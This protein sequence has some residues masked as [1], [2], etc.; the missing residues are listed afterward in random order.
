MP[1]SKQI[2]RIAENQVRRDRQVKQRASTMSFVL[3]PDQIKWIE[4]QAIEHDLN[5]SAFV[6]RVIDAMMG[7]EDETI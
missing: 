6:R 7:G 3:R 4:E 2:E 5:N 1:V